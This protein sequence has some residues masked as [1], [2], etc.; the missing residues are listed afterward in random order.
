M[1]LNIPFK[2]NW[3]DIYHE[4]PELTKQ[5]TYEIYTNIVSSVIFGY[6]LMIDHT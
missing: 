6:R 3:N 1:C 4:N 2:I 5:M